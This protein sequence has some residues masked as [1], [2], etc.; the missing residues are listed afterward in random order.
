LSDE[1]K[2]YRKPTRMVFTIGQYDVCRDCFLME[3]DKES[4]T[5]DHGT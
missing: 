2:E 1:E 3:A 5:D 4:V